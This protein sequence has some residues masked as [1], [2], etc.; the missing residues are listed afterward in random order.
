MATVITACRQT[1][2]LIVYA[3]VIHLCTEF[4]IQRIHKGLCVLWVTPDWRLRASDCALSEDSL[5][6]VLEIGFPLQKLADFVI[7]VFSVMYAS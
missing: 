5:S 3:F 1:V 7:I 2:I 4:L 6:R